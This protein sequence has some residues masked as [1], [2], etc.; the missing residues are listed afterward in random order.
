MDLLL[1]KT[2]KF[3]FCWMVGQVVLVNNVLERS[4]FLH[5]ERAFADEIFSLANKSWM[6]SDPEAGR[7]AP[8]VNNRYTGYRYPFSISTVKYEYTVALSLV[9]GSIK[10]FH[11]CDRVN[12][13]VFGGCEID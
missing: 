2:V 13:T 8:I 11:R 9:L 12:R 3:G 6:E 1:C 10:N 4:S 7:T 5:Q